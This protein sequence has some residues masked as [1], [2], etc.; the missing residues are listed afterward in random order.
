[1]KK[2]Q[3][4][5]I[6]P[7]FRLQR[8][9]FFRIFLK[10]FIKLTRSNIYLLSFEKNKEI[11]KDWN[12]LDDIHVSSFTWVTTKHNSGDRT[13]WLNFGSLL[14]RAHKNCS[15][16]NRKKVSYH[17]KDFHMDKI[18]PFCHV[19]MFCLRVFNVCVTGGHKLSGTSHVVFIASFTIHSHLIHILRRYKTHNR[20]WSHESCCG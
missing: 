16:T 9:F 15:R 20:W 5:C 8:S 1:M 3:D 14:T 2:F 6:N 4:F 17:K 7:I 19:C 18:F 12:L 11:W 10:L 13:W